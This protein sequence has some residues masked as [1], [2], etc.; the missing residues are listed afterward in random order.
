MGNLLSD[1]PDNKYYQYIFYKNEGTI[2]DSQ[3]YSHFN[4]ILSKGSQQGKNI[5]HRKDSNGKTFQQTIDFLKYIAEESLDKECSFYDK[6]FGEKDFSNAVRDAASSMSSSYMNTDFQGTPLYQILNFKVLGID[7]GKSDK[8]NFIQ[9]ISSLNTQQ[10]IDS[11]SQ[12]VEQSLFTLYDNT[13]KDLFLEQK[14]A[15]YNGA[16]LK[17]GEVMYRGINMEKNAEFLAE[18]LVFQSFDDGNEEEAKKKILAFLMKGNKIKRGQE[19]TDYGQKMIYDFYNQAKRIH[20]EMIEDLAE[21]TTEYIKEDEEAQFKNPNYKKEEAKRI[22][23]EIIEGVKVTSGSLKPRGNELIAAT[24]SYK[25]ETLRENIIKYYQSAIQKETQKNLN[26]INI[27]E[28]TFFK[29]EQNNLVNKNI[30]KFLEVLHSKM[31]DFIGTGGKTGLGPKGINLAQNYYISLI[32]QINSEIEKDFNLEGSNQKNNANISQLWTEL[33]SIKQTLDK[34]GSLKE[35]LKYIENIIDEKL[36]PGLL[37]SKD[38]KIIKDKILNIILQTL[39][40]DKN[41]F[42][43][44]KIKYTK[45]QLEQMINDKDLGTLLNLLRK[46]LPEKIRGYISNFNGSLGEIYFTVLTRIAFGKSFTTS[47]FG[48]ARN[49]LS[50]QAHADLGF[51]TGSLDNQDGWGVQ[52]KIYKDNQVDLYRDTKVSF[53]AKDAIRYLGSANE[54]TAFRFFIINNTILSD[55]KQDLEQ[56]GYGFLNVLEERLDYFI[57]YSDG[58]TTLGTLK[59]NFFMINF[60]LVPTSAVFFAM[61]EYFQSNAEKLISIHLNFPN[62][63][64]SI[65]APMNW[66]DKTV[67]SQNGIN[68]LKGNYAD[69]KGFSIDLNKM[70]IGIFNK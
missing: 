4:N 28:N 19:K 36:V 52:A 59:N 51:Y 58:L 68:L 3:S 40:T 53:D 56:D 10:I 14:T 21:K 69:F 7:N 24:A 15:R 49:E 39:K 45:D 43:V 38:G 63:L 62:V 54:L 17:E 9:I 50:Q 13:I 70:G 41:Y 37:D 67:D 35:S 26:K 33:Q 16:P 31:I 47:Q 46:R 22:A 6:I 27:N 23:K 18:N 48:R 8:Y 42:T 20:D 65:Y 32:P 44:N 1:I 5:L 60:N 30:Q 66:E 61:I 29:N 64:E 34:I 55:I 12:T 11:S 2:E 25:T 57:R